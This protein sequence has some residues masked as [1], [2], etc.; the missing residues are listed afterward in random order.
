M[1]ESDLND[2][3]NFLDRFVKNT[4]SSAR[5][6][7]PEELRK[8]EF[9]VSS[10][11]YCP[12]VHLKKLLEYHRATEPMDYSMA[13]YT[14]IGTVVH[15][16][17]Q[18]FSK[19]A[20]PVSF[21]GQWKCGR[22]L[23]VDHEGDKTTIRKCSRKSEDITSYQDLKVGTCPHGK[24]GCKPYFEYHEIPISFHGLS[25][26][27]DALI[28]RGDEIWVLD[29]K[30]THD[31]LWGAQKDV[32]QMI[33]KGYYPSAKYITQIETYCALLE[34]QFG[35]NIGGYSICYVNRNKTMNVSG[36]RQVRSWRNFVYRWTDER[37]AAARERISRE[38]RGNKIVK[39]LLVKD[40]D[41]DTENELIRK[42]LD[43]RPCKSE[44]SY[45][46]NM[47]H[48]WFGDE[49]CPFFG[50][51]WQNDDKMFNEVKDLLAQIREYEYGEVPESDLADF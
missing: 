35:L 9:R 10:L 14:G 22:T 6:P 11:P 38:V 12:V 3:T 49:E 24:S 34:K 30:T 51:C 27:V 15:E 26:H 33:K 8:P 47:S 18:G 29:F 43:Q 45:K 31:G 25:G 44:S 41:E 21:M 50:V 4:I 1:A 48:S 20:N 17:M 37:R 19:E 36:Y 16:V 39:Q 42:L 46:K 32:D 23:S 13:F 2:V 40:I 7:H 5:F 28:K